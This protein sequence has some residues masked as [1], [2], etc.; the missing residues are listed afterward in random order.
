MRSGHRGI[1]RRLLAIILLGSVP[2]WIIQ[3][4]LAW[5]YLPW[6]VYP[7]ITLVSVTGIALVATAATVVRQ[8]ATRHMNISNLI[9]A[10]RVGDYSLRMRTS[11]DDAFAELAAEINQLAGN[12]H[13]QRLKSE[14]ALRLVDSVVDGIDVAIFA[15]DDDGEMKLANPAACQLL[16]RPTQAVLGRSALELGLAEL[17]LADPQQTYEWVFPG[18]AGLWRVRRQGYRVEGRL[19]TLLFVSDLKQALRS[20]ELKAWRELIR[21]LSHEVNNS[22]GPIASV[23]CTLRT[24]MQRERRPEDW[25]PELHEGLDIIEE[26]ARRLGEFVRRYAALAR[27][28][29]PH[30]QVFDMGALL[31]RL[32]AMRWSAEV[33][34]EGPDQ[35]YRF[36]GDP[37]QIEQLLINL[38]KNGLEAGGAPIILRW[39][40][41]PLQ[42]AVLDHGTGIANPGN[43]FVP[44]YTTK[45]TGSGIG[46]VLCRQIIEAHNGTLTL[47]NRNGEPGCVA[48]LRF[49]VPNLSTGDIPVDAER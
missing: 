39:T 9:E 46:L 45:G 36:F 33:R 12:L 16:Q 32:P 7:K 27:L 1:D 40:T 8:I 5:R 4:L 47:Q 29:D 11:A 34:V 3:A 20:E 10:I 13:Q 41:E 17:L 49:A 26:R 24:L 31:R 48:T 38:I 6:T 42:I 44:F 30:K 43:L 18:G 37:S 19:H 15:V 25:E 2:T 35:P 21:V 28:P 14:E 22:L 23:S